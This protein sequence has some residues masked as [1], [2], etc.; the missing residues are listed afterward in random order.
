MRYLDKDSAAYKEAVAAGVNPSL[1]YAVDIRPPGACNADEAAYCFEVSEKEIN[2]KTVAMILGT[3]SYSVKATGV[4]PDANTTTKA[5]LQ[6][7]RPAQ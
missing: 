4:G 7:F 2:R 3:R 1:L 6:A 5:Q